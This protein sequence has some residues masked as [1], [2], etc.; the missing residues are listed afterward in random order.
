MKRKK[1]GIGDQ[2][3]VDSIV[4]E[5]RFVNNGIAWVCPVIEGWLKDQYLNPS[6]AFARIE[7]DGKT[8]RL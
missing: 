3:V 8:V 4:C 5:V 6:I 2:V 1:L 7:R